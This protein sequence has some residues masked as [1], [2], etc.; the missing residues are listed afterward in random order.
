M[1]KGFRNSN[2]QYTNINSKSRNGSFGLKSWI[3]SF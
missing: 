2:V 1:L 3:S